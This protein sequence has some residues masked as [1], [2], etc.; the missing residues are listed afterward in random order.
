MPNK[1]ILCLD[2]DGCVH[3][4]SRGWQDGTIYDDIVDGFFEWAEEA[5]MYFKLVIYSSRSK[6]PDQLKL[7]ALWLY[8]QR[9]KWAAAQNTETLMELEIEFA[10]EKPAAWLTIDDRCY[11]FYGDWNATNLSPEAIL[12]FRPWNSPKA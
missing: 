3:L 6:D 10:S 9:N 7:M 4:Y 8:E 12:A 11:Q 1:P 5:Q 2:F